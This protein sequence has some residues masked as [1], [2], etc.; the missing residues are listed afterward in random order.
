MRS[1][2]RRLLDNA[3]VILVIT[4][5]P[6]FLGNVVVVMSLGGFGRLSFPGLV[7]AIVSGAFTPALLIGL[8]AIAHYL[9]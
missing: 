6:V 1:G 3:P 8:A 2:L 5:L 4:A 9:G 7:S